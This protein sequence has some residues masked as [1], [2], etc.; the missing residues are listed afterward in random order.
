[1]SAHLDEELVSPV[2][3][4]LKGLLHIDVTDQHAAV[5]AAVEGHPQALEALLACCVPDLQGYIFL[6]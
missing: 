5:R 3:Q 6:G 1:M 2:V 4:V